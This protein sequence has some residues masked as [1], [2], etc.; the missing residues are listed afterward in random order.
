VWVP[1][2]SC[3]QNAAHILDHDCAGPDFGNDP[4]S[5]GKEIPLVKVA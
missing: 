4:Q 2:R 3:I 5:G 1:S